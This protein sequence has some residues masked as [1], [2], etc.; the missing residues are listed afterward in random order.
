MPVEK[1]LEPYEPQGVLQSIGP[2]IWIVEGP[3]IGFRWLGLRLP[4]TTRMTIVRLADGGL[5][6]HSPV[7]LG[8]DLARAIDALGPVRHLVAP[9]RI[10]YWWLPAWQHRYPGALGWACPDDQSRA[11]RHG[12][13][14][15]GRLGE[16]PPLAWRGQIEQLLV[17]GWF[18]TEAVF[19]HTASSTLILTDLIESFEADRIKSPVFRFLCGATGAL[20]PD[21]KMPLDLRMTFL[22]RGGELRAAVRRMI[23]WRPERIVIA[24]GRWY[25]E[26]AE[27]E[28]RRAFRWVG[29][30]EP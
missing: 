10:H 4:F 8:A 27:A 2:E 30:L 25:R 12:V 18:M 17:P 5:W 7:E 23:G 19:F 1:E 11:L 24:H 16:E 28:L 6:V 13:R 3:V 9:N 22:G 15:D 14:I 29:P 21:G 26:N 20:H